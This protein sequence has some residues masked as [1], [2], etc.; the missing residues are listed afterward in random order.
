MRACILSIGSELI[1][2]Q[3]TDTNATFL[4]QELSAVGID[5]V[6]VIQ[7]G[8][9]RQQLADALRHVLALSDFVICTGGIGPTDD[10]CTREA[11]ADVVGETPATDADLLD[12][13]TSFFRARG[14]EMPARNAK[15]AWVI[16]S[17]TVLPNP[18][19]T[20]PGWMVATSDTPPRHMF[21]MPG[22]PR[23]MFRMWREQVLPRIMERVDQ[24][25]IDSTIIK[26]IG[27]GES[28]AEQLLHALVVAADPVVATYAKD[29]GVHVRV[30]AVGTDARE[31]RQRRDVA[32]RE[33]TG[34][35]GEYI[36]GAD[37]DTLPSVLAAR[38]TETGHRLGIL[39]RGTGGA[40]GLLLAGDQRSAE[41]VSEG[42]ILPFVPGIDA[43]EG[44]S[45]AE[46]DASSAA[47]FDGAT[48]GMG[49]VFTGVPVQ[50]GL[51]AGQLHLA[52]AAQGNGSQPLPSLS[53]RAT[54]P[55]VQRRAS[56]HAVDMLRR[57]LAV[58]R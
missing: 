8:D 53:L 5:L 15:Q 34:I 54:L 57:H 27:I 2:G 18:V 47:S 6:H 43:S 7:V 30:T 46:N 20:A 23:E 4:A 32:V 49:L 45:L 10:D 40:F 17:C 36:W 33:V 26:T 11:I 1:L 19:G 50:D 41:R 39:E 56:L 24:R 48:L 16:P 31:T 37:A 22:V 3:L 58:G 25:V 14:Q 51:V 38:L 29:D 52:V 42:R 55:E 21:A 35:L 44:G 28:A 12:N 13:L 9:D